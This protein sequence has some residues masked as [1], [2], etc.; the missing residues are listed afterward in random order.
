MIKDGL[1]VLSWYF[2]G[3]LTVLQKCFKGLVG[4]LGGSVGRLLEV[5]GRVM[6][7]ALPRIICRVF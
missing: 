7:K 5:F 4:V 3:T 6:F 2:N 1:A